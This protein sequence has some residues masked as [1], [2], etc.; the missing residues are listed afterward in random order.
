M[1][2]GNLQS[3]LAADRRGKKKDRHSDEMQNEANCRHVWPV[4][5]QKK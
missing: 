2:C 1:P 4:D 5:G 3:G